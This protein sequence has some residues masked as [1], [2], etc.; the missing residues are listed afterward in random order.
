MRVHYVASK[1]AIIGFTRTLAREVGPDNITVNCIAP[2]ATLSE[3]DPSQEVIE[4]RG[5]KTSDRAIARVQVPEDLTGA[6][7]FFASEDSDFVTG[8]TLVVDGGSAMH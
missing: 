1:A 5:K 3:E 7:A 4:A 2:G 6:M 8:Q